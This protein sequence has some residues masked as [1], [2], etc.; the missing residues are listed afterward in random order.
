VPLKRKTPL[1]FTVGDRTFAVFGSTISA[2]NTSRWNTRGWTYQEALLSRRRLVFTD[3]RV[4]MQCCSE[5]FIECED[6][7]KRW[8]PSKE[9]PRIFPAQGIGSW[10]L[11]VYDRLSEYYLRDL[12][13]A[14]DNIKAFEG[15]F[16][17][18][19]RLRASE[20]SP[21]VAHFYGVPILY[22]E[23]RISGS[24]NP[25]VIPPGRMDT[26]GGNASFALGL[27]WCSGYHNPSG[28][29]HN[30]L[31]PSWTWAASGPGGQPM[32]MGDQT[33]L[34]F[35]F[36]Y[37]VIRQLDRSIRICLL[38]RSGKSTTLIEYLRHQEHY[39]KFHPLVDITSYV[40]Y[41]MLEGIASWKSRLGK[42]QAWSDS[43]IRWQPEAMSP[44]N[45]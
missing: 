35:V 13:Y 34:N 22:D 28:I 24:P 45:E 23:Q 17:A 32:E 11:G 5:H 9:D 30:D 15:V 20:N 14:T 7:R 29:V 8:F 27:A 26:F 12:S 19:S 10:P 38:H 36:Q 21:S 41:D 6:Q 43:R 16:Q 4:Y 1:S 33:S 44:V 39:T 2:V 42:L 18:F 25:E 40:V 31:F 3:T 37:Q